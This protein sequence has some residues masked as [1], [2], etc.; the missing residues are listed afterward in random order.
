MLGRAMSSG[1][2]HFWLAMADDGCVHNSLMDHADWWHDM[3]QLLLMQLLILLILLL[4][5]SSKVSAS[6]IVSDHMQR[7]CCLPP[8]LR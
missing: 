2:L 1:L 5:L 7:S 3:M 4:L 8:E 6:C